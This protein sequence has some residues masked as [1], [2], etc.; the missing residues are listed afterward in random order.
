MQHLGQHRDLSYSLHATHVILWN[1]IA[2]IRIMHADVDSF[3]AGLTPAVDVTL[4]PLIRTNYGQ[5]ESWLL[6][7]Y[8][9]YRDIDATISLSTFV[10]RLL[11]PALEATQCQP[12][13]YSLLSTLCTTSISDLGILELN[14]ATLPEQLLGLRLEASMWRPL[15]LEWSILDGRDP[16]TAQFR[17]QLSHGTIKRIMPPLGAYRVLQDIVRL[18]MQRALGLPADSVIGCVVHDLGRVPSATNTRNWWNRR[19]LQHTPTLLAEVAG[20]SITLYYKD[21]A[22]MLSRDSIKALHR[23]FITCVGVK[24][25][26]L[27][28]E[29][30]AI[31]AFR[32]S[33]HRFLSRNPLTAAFMNA[34]Q[35]EVGLNT[36]PDKIAFRHFLEA[37]L[38]DLLQSTS[39]EIVRAIMHRTVNQ[40]SQPLRSQ[41]AVVGN[42]MVD[43][44]HSAPEWATWTVPTYNFVISSLV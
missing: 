31:K 17:L 28:S 23:N 43:A 12:S 41:D 42:Y 25:F 2:G 10:S 22:I 8:Q 40:P 29:V 24:I 35:A 14:E 19:L 15:N 7:L 37:S 26:D 33:T 9:L 18:S 34:P 30:P 16:L 36:I 39:A 1:Q 13:D 38:A 11:V 3:F 21:L 32:R 44:I 27:V 5:L 6:V 4:T 20:E